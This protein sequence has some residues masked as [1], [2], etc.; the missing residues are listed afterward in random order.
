MELKANSPRAET[1]SRGCRSAA[2]TENS[3]RRGSAQFGEVKQ[4]VGSTKKRKE[5]L[6]E[7]TKTIGSSVEHSGRQRCDETRLQPRRRSC[8]FSATAAA[9][10]GLGSVPKLGLGSSARVGATI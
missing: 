2:A 8:P 4:S 6:G 10:L 7:V 5:R 1:G 9:R 3:G